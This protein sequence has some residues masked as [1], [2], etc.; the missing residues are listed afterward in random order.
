M[1][2]INKAYLLIGGNVGNMFLHL[3]QSVSFLNNECG[4]VTSYSSVYETAA[5]GNE[6]QP[7]FL[8]QAL[9]LETIYPAEALMPKLLLIEER[10][11]RKRISKYG[12]RI[13]D[14]DILLFNED[15]INKPGLVIPHEELQNRLF[16]L[17]PLAE[18]A[19][20][21]QHPVLKKSIHQLVKECDDKLKVEKVIPEIPKF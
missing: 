17:I 16:A 14:I 20:N 12:P 21:M 2:F 10:M 13:I 11:G 6:D 19:G 9:E 15:I 4:K 3:H 8:N 7:P 18:I 1:Q 5:W